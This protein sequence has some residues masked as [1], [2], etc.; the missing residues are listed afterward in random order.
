MVIP[1]AILLLLRLFFCILGFLPFQMKLRIVLSIYL[2]NC[3]GIL[4]EISLNLWVAFGR[5]D[6]FTIITSPNSDTFISS[7]AICI[8]VM[9][10]CCQTVVPST[11]STVLNRYGEKEHPC[12]LPDF[13]GVVS[14][15]CPFNLTLAVGFQ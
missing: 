11:M 14:N 15:M 5:M 2:K 4:M 13:S 8:P 3:V 12:L 10:F 1:T 9:S 7:L 6:I